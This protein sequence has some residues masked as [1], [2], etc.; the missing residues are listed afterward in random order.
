MQLPPESE[1]A[2]KGQTLD[3]PSAA[4]AEP[5]PATASVATGATPSTISFDDSLAGFR[6][7][8]GHRPAA[9]SHESH[10]DHASHAVQPIDQEESAGHMGGHT[11]FWLW[12]MCLT[13]VDYF[14]TLGYQPAIA[15]EAAGVLAPLAT[16]VLVLVTLLGALPVYSHVAASSPRGQGSIAML[17]RLVHGWTGKTMV[18]ALLGFAATDFVITMTLSAADAAVHLIENPLWRSMPAWIQTLSDDRQRL[19]VTVFM[20]VLLGACFLRGFKEVIGLAVGIVGVYLA[21]N[22]LVLISGLAYLAAHPGLLEEWYAKLTSGN[23]EIA[24]APLSGHGWGTIAALS[25]LYF[26]KL[27]LGLSGFETGVAVMP[28]IRGG[29]HDTPQN[30]AG[31]IRNTRK[32]LVTAAAIMCVCLLASSML[33]ATL[34]PAAELHEPAGKAAD[35]ALAYLAHGQS[36]YAINPLFG[37]VFG[38]I[39]DVSTVVIL[40]FAGASAMAGLLN[41]VPQYLPRYGMA[42][43]WARAVRP[44]VVLFALINLLVTWIFDADVGAQGGAYATGVLVLMSSACTATVIDHWRDSQGAWYRRL[45]WRYLAITCI[46]YYTTAANMIER[47]DG[48]KIASWFIIA[49]VLSSFWSRVQRS[50]ELR[51]KAFEFADLHSKFLWDSLKHLEF[52]VLVPHRP[53]RRGLDVKEASI[54]ERHRLGSDVPIVFVEAALGDPSEFQHSP[55]MEIHEEDGRFILSV[56]RCASV[57]HV[58]ATVALELSR[59]GA[60]PEIHFGWSDENPLSAAI[61]FFLFGEGNVPWRVRDLIRKAEPDV[62]RQPKVILG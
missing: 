60:P 20:L 61:G 23:W 3:C 36:P 15:F 41:L 52:P 49:I 57:A 58:I 46:F 55:L 29:D 19:G 42:P 39:Y 25:V 17:E 31:R 7:P 1:P 34:I 24:E 13:G 51:F 22:A 16:V 6:P 48:I 21:L 4:A 18:L 53:G 11:S 9:E 30:P 10:P 38:T 35:R 26:P 54:R 14:S 33:V 2:P 27:A 43:E 40:G 45:S 12:V 47:P 62:E 37:E 44:L 5:P 28:L 59:V 8:P 32:L 56:Q 50:S